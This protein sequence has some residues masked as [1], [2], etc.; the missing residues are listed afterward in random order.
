LV[1]YNFTRYAFGYFLPLIKD[2]HTVSQ[3]RHR[4]YDVFNP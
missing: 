1:G 4:A 2:G 3:L